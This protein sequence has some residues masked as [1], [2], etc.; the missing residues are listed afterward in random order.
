MRTSAPLAVVLAAAASGLAAAE[1]PP[2]RGDDLRLVYSLG[3]DRYTIT[4]PVVGQEGH[5][6]RAQ[7]VRLDLVRT[8]QPLGVGVS[9]AGQRNDEARGGADLTY[10]AVSG[11]LNVGMAVAPMRSL[12]VEVLPFAGYGLS[13]LELGAAPG[14][15][16]PGGRGRDDF[17]EYGLNVNAVVT[18]GRGLQMGAGVGYLVNESS[19]AFDVPAGG[20]VTVEQSGPVYGIFIGTRH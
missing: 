17:F 18:T 6:D 8:R 10:E 3:A 13:G 20:A 5:W 19:Y 9:V 2:G 15:G 4:S 12:Q 7:G 14:A 1:E 16:F 11:R